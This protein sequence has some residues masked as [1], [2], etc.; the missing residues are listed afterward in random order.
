MDGPMNL[1]PERRLKLDLLKDH[2]RGIF[3]VVAEL[4]GFGYIPNHSG[5]LPEAIDKLYAEVE[6]GRHPC[7]DVK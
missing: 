7:I 5:N 3:K 6:A 4:R 1:D 2:F